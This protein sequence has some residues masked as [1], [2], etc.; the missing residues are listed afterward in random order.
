MSLIKELNS[1]NKVSKE[2]DR[3]S[4]TDEHEEYITRIGEGDVRKVLLKSIRDADKA[5]RN[6]KIQFS[7]YMA[8]AGQETA[9]A[10]E[11]KESG[12]IARELSAFISRRRRRTRNQYKT[13]VGRKQFDLKQEADIARIEASLEQERKFNEEDSKEI[14]N[15]HFFLEPIRKHYLSMEQ[16]R[17][18]E[19]LGSIS[20]KC[21]KALANP[22]DIKLKKRCIKDLPDKG[23]VFNRE[24]QRVLA[25]INLLNLQEVMRELDEDLDNFE[26]FIIPEMIDKFIRNFSV[27]DSIGFKKKQKALRPIKTKEE[28]NENLGKLVSEENQ[29]VAQ[30]KVP[31]LSL[32]EAKDLIL[33]LS[34]LQVQKGNAVKADKL[35]KEWEVAKAWLRD[36]RHRTIPAPEVPEEIAD[37][38][39]TLQRKMPDIDDSN[40]LL[41]NID[42]LFRY[43]ELYKFPIKGVK[44]EGVVTKFIV[45]LD[46]DKKERIQIEK[47]KESGTW[48]VA[49]NK[50]TENYRTALKQRDLLK[51]KIVREE[52]YLNT[53]ID[54]AV[55]AE[56]IHRS[57]RQRQRDILLS[58][59]K[60]IRNECLQ[61]NSLTRFN[62]FVIS[63]GVADFTEL[64][65][66][67]LAFLEK[68]FSL[69]GIGVYNNLV[70]LKGSKKKRL[71]ELLNSR[72]LDD[73]SFRELK[74]LELKIFPSLVT[75]PRLAKLDNVKRDILL[76]RARKLGEAKNMKDLEKLDIKTFDKLV[77]KDWKC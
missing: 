23:E 26:D 54:N 16:F 12:E 56:R 48:G 15:W 39:N 40:K 41:N 70:A 13:T 67:D 50:N 11:K 21:L 7:K 6:K 30:K 35:D 4:R 76:E 37:T 32:D 20:S 27:E 62:L 31:K 65:N 42:I 29:K 38:L 1:I 46:F 64:E 63:R 33:E 74:K 5:F 2:A 68:K 49:Q 77:D 22:D 24:V 61:G 69:D 8:K 60:R 55:E 44:S 58:E 73:L 14:P 28:L 71:D 51:Q 17:K 34:K 66:E 75:K 47:L 19:S 10:R 3:P 45:E 18:G 59:V 36:P 52:I 9:E 53:A 43:R 25:Q 72:D 57:G